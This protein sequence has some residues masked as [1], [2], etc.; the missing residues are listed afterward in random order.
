M[1]EIF[2][3]GN[4]EMQNKKI[5]YITNDKN[6]SQ[7]TF[8]DNNEN[9]NQS[10]SQN[11]LDSPIIDDLNVI[12]NNNQQIDYQNLSNNNNIKE[13]IIN[14]YQPNNENNYFNNIEEAL[15]NSY[16]NN[17]NKNYIN[18]LINYDIP[19]QINNNYSLDNIDSKAIY[20]NNNNNIYTNYINYC[21]QNERID[22]QLFPKNNSLSD[23]LRI[24]NTKNDKQK[25]KEIED[26]FLNG[27]FTNRKK[28]YLKGSKIN[29]TK[30]S[31]NNS[32][33]NSKKLPHI[34]IP[35]EFHPDF[36]KYFYNKDDPFFNYEIN[37][38]TPRIQTTMTV[39]NPQYSNIIETYVG[40]IN[41]KGEKHGFGKLISENVTKIG[42]WRHNEFTGWGREI[43]RDGRIYEGKFING[44]IFG[45]GI[46][47]DDSM[48]YTGYFHNS[49]KNGFGELFTK[50]Y[51]FLGNIVNDSFE[52]EGRIDIYNEGSY[53]GNFDN[54]K[55]NGYGIFKWTNGDYYEGYMKNG[56]MDG[57]GK[58]TSANGNT[59]EGQF[60][61][62]KMHGIGTLRKSDGTV[63]KGKF[64]NGNHV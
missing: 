1:V 55:I 48:L 56:I 22:L 8:Q 2:P 14:D 60:K 59:Y 52:G 5:E 3:Y 20:N 63:F 39:N 15:N 16:L 11:D 34:L 12:Y 19:A 61:N 49:I 10:L 31:R 62:G 43:W 32:I 4:P 17:D 6:Y 9:E 30:K 58:L 42:T 40:E 38:K 64:V 18:E 36:W 45:K 28:N 51:H 21:N 50:Y 33:M 23:P 44:K 29:L 47:K 27:V 35:K 57:Y 7:F 24:Y 53:E 37:N 41:E 26:T 54:G 13:K 25:F 46:Y